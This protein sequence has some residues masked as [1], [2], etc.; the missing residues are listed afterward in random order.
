ML[1]DTCLS[2]LPTAQLPSLKKR[3][4]LKVTDSENK[5]GSEKGKM[6]KQFAGQYVWPL[7]PLFIEIEGK[8]C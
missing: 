7:W 2:E 5:F 8:R 4:G 3:S 6:T 1:S